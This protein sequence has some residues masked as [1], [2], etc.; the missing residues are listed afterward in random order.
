[1]RVW[2]QDE[3]DF[4]RDL[5]DKG[6][7]ARKIAKLL[8]Q[9]FTTCFYTRNSV[10]GKL[11]RMGLCLHLSKEAHGL[12]VQE[13]MRQAKKS[14]KPK[15]ATYP[16]PVETETPPECAVTFENLEDDHCRYPFGESPSIVFCGR[17]K[18]LGSSFCVNHHIKC[19]SVR[20]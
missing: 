15:L 8:K 17:E 11:H 14:A 5:K 2:S 7:S 9:K 1:M 16:L 6:H 10:L 19:Y 20:T 13:G 4:L 3:M 18:M 12:R